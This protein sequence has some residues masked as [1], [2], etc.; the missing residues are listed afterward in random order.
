LFKGLPFPPVVL[1][2]PQHWASVS[3]NGAP[4]SEQGHSHH[5]KEPNLYKQQWSVTSC[6]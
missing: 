5:V 6:D 1:Y 2:C 4:A 3:Q